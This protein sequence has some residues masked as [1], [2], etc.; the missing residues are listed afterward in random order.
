VV[1]K[2]GERRGE[3]RGEGRIGQLLYKKPREKEKKTNE[4]PAWWPWL[5]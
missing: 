1:E 3:K 5:P 4:W 2:R